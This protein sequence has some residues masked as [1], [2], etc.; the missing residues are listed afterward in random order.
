MVR[1]TWIFLA[2]ATVGLLQASPAAAETVSLA[3]SSTPGGSPT[4]YYSVDITNTRVTADSGTYAADVT[5]Q[6]VTWRTP[7]RYVHGGHFPATSYALDRQS[8][9]LNFGGSDFAGQ[10]YCQRGA[11]PAPVL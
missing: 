4:T 2:L 1:G 9:T 8:G 11:R 3:C 5:T 10:F 7:D 6:T